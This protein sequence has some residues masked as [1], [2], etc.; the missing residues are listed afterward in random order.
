M[1]STTISRLPFYD[2]KN[3]NLTMTLGTPEEGARRKEYWRLRDLDVLAT[4]HCDVIDFDS[5]GYRAQ[6]FH[7]G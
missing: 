6:L 3:I 1:I 7:Y 4:A 2:A 5:V